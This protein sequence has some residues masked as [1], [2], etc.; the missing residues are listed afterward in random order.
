MLV[1]AQSPAF[2]ELITLIS[3]S[4]GYGLIIPAHKLWHELTN[5]MI[6]VKW[7]PLWYLM[8]SPLLGMPG[9]TIC[10]L[11]SSKSLSIFTRSSSTTAAGRSF[12]WRSMY[13][14]ANLSNKRGRACTWGTLHDP[15]CMFVQSTCPK[16]W[17]HLD[18]S[19]QHS[20]SRPWTMCGHTCIM[21]RCSFAC[22]LA[23][24]G[25]YFLDDYGSW[26]SSAYAGQHI[27]LCTGTKRSLPLMHFPLKNPPARG[28]KRILSF[29]S[30]SFCFPEQNEWCEMFANKMRS[31]K[32]LFLHHVSHDDV[33][34]EC[35]WEADLMASLKSNLKHPWSSTRTRQDLHCA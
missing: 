6:C 8:V 30:C 24:S 9:A 18:I 32:C 35:A 2:Q 28:I 4:N 17:S 12:L 19:S 10:S 14:V 21:F 29:R 31:V 15:R 26:K 20:S 27:A 33:Q 16:Q 23:W 25:K 5:L 13:K 3:L 7:P 22:T 11:K 34:A 1:I